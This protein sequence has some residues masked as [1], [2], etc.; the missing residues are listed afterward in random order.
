MTNE[1]VYE[2]LRAGTMERKEAIRILNENDIKGIL[3]YKQR[4]DKIREC[5][6]GYFKDIDKL[7]WDVTDDC[8]SVSHNAADSGYGWMAEIDVHLGV[9]NDE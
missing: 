7:K 1:E 9:K 6:E 4:L 2:C 8:D 5:V 3:S